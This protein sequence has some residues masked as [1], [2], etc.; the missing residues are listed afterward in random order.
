[1]ICI[2]WPLHKVRGASPETEPMPPALEAQSLNH[3][4]TRKFPKYAYYSFVW[5]D[6]TAK[7]LLHPSIRTGYINYSLFTLCDKI[8]LVKRFSKD[9]YGIP[10]L[11]GQIIN[12]NPC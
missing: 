8:Q 6:K 4:T 11:C 7:K 2:N 12:I 9:L 10:K 5:N 1:M 3:S